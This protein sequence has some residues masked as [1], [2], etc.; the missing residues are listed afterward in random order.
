MKITYRLNDKSADITIEG[1]DVND[2][3]NKLPLADQKRAREGVEV[4][5]QAED[6]AMFLTFELGYIVSVV[7]E[8]VPA[9]VADTSNLVDNTVTDAASSQAVSE[10]P[11]SCCHND[12]GCDE[13]PVPS[14][15]G[16]SEA[17]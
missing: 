5:A 12:C 15:D 1:E 7:D 9:T 6:L 8:G 17:A 4:T 10:A 13:Q 3:M 2:L 11:S 14:T 16:N